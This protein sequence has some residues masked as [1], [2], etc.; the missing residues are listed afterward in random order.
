MVQVKVF[1]KIRTLSVPS[2]SSA[3][4]TLKNGG[5]SFNKNPP[6]RNAVNKKASKI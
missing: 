1:K 3:S 4:Q 6:T 5:I 2:G